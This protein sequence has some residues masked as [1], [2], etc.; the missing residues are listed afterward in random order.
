MSQTPVPDYGSLA[1]TL[2]P[3]GVFSLIQAAGQQQAEEL[4]RRTQAATQAGQQA[5][6]QYTQA[7]AAPPPDQGLAG[8]IPQLFGNMASVIAENPMYAQQAERSVERQRADAMKARADNLQAL[9]EIYRQR[10]DEAQKAG[11]LE[12]ALTSRTKLESLDKVR[13]QVTLNVKRA[14]DLAAAEEKK[15]QEAL[16]R[17][18]R[19]QTSV[20]GQGVNP[21]GLAFGKAGE[22][23][24]YVA[25]TGLGLGMGGGGAEGG[26][27]V[28]KV[29]TLNGPEGQDIQV[30]NTGGAIGNTKNA[31]LLWAN[32]N[33]VPSLS[34]KEL[35]VAQD[36]QGARDNISDILS[37]LEATGRQPQTP[38]QRM[39]AFVGLRGGAMSQVFP[40]E[41]AFNSWRTAA[42]RNL[43]ATAGSGG[44]RINQREIELA[45]ANDLPKYTDT[46]EVSRQKMENIRAM[47][48]NGLR[49]LVSEDWRRATTVAN[50]SRSQP[51]TGQVEMI[52]PKGE[53]KKVPVGRVTS[54]SQSGWARIS[55]MTQSAV[56]P[57]AEPTP[58]GSF[59]DSVGVH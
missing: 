12:T 32:Q 22:L 9:Q 53:R 24:P 30:Y 1:G 59:L 13:E 29:I 27:P 7:A 21:G 57:S 33:K 16:D 45:V 14:D 54:M 18:N 35:A 26:P 28:G 40:T 25:K 41:A 19:L 58:A 34:D 5:Q 42:I 50:K 51:A 55:I 52:G 17:A 47:L 6:Q 44:L 39:G 2:D 3:A 15:R 38:F 20:I 48:N 37:Q 23:L 49:P 43:R 56:P 31:G 46:F 10:A 4:A 11:D 36:I 8:M